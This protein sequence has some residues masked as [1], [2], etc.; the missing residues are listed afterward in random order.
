MNPEDFG[1]GGTSDVVET[2]PPIEEKTDLE[3]GEVGVE[4]K[5]NL[6]AEEKGS[7]T[8]GA[9]ETGDNNGTSSTGGQEESNLNVGD[10]VEVDGVNYTVNEDGALV[11]EKGEVFKTKEEVAELLKQYSTEEVGETS[12]INI[13]D[14]Q[15]LIGINVEDENGKAVTFESTP[16]NV[17]PL[18]DP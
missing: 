4:G 3:T 1:F 17:L 11:D 13:E 5:T 7:E 14:I 18:F 12:S 6:D 15:K 8:K 16:S 10:S 9:N 2:T